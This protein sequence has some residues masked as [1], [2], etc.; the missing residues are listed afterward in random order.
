MH[1]DAFDGSQDPGKDRLNRL[2]GQVEELNALIRKVKRIK[3][4]TATEYVDGQMIVD[5]DRSSGIK[6]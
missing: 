3:S 4:Y 5:L 6:G 1:H 2:S